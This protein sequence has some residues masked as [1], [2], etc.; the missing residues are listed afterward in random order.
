MIILGFNSVS[1]S[2][3]S[4]LLEDSASD[5]SLDSVSSV[6]QDS[7]FTY[8]DNGAIDDTEIDFDDDSSSISSSNSL[9]ESSD[10]VYVS[11]SG[12]DDNDGSVESP[13][14][15][16]ERGIQLATSETGSHKVFVFE[17][18]YLVYDIDLDYTD[19]II[20]G[21]GIDKTIF[22]GVGYTLLMQ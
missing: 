6:E 17:G 10:S 4:D 3:S 1:A 20:E 5:L 19:L 16:V 9:K 7:S 22:D 8:S 21:S 14:R 12:N 18:T 13:V 15:T 2:D 11:L